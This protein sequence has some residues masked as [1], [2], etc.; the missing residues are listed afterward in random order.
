[1]QITINGQ[2]LI[3][4]LAEKLS[5]LGC[6]IIQANTD[7][8]TILYKKDLYDNIDSICKDWQ[9]LTKLE[10]EYAKY[11]KMVIRDVKLAS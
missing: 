11:R 9:T 7:G 5:A 4:M 3:L 8:I 10:L 6:Q 1:M 2:L